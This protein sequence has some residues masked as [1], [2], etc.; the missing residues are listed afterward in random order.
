MHLSVDREQRI[1]VAAVRLH[2][3]DERLADLWRLQPG[4][5]PLKI[6]EQRVGGQI[7]PGTA[8]DPP[9]EDREVGLHRLLRQVCAPHYCA[10]ADHR[11]PR[12][13]VARARRLCRDDFGSFVHRCVEQEAIEVA[14]ASCAPARAGAAEHR[15]HLAPCGHRQ[16][17]ALP[18]AVHH[19]LGSPALDDLLR[20]R[21]S[22][23]RGGC[24]PAWGRYHLRSSCS[25][26]R[27]RRPRGGRNRPR[28]FSRE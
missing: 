15:E 21:R 10:V 28:S 6:G 23:P 2:L 7:H 9:R 26:P 18:V 27:H 1:R 25:P 17:H 3:G 24:R 8:V 20:Q 12:L 5:H 19:H 11:S 14:V 13:R 16:P 4:D 22:P